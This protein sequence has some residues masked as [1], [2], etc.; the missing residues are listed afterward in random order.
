MTGAVLYICTYT[1][2]QSTLFGDHPQLASRPSLLACPSNLGWR[3]W[4][5]SRQPSC[6]CPMTCG[7]ATHGQHAR[8]HRPTQMAHMSW[9]HFILVC[10][11]G[12][13][14]GCSSVASSPGRPYLQLPGMRARQ[15][16]AWP[17]LRGD[18]T[19]PAQT[20]KQYD[21]CRSQSPAP[22][23]QLFD[24]QLPPNGSGSG[25]TLE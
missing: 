1:H 7:P 2:G 3:R 23:Q 22:L 17:M 11:W 20:P 13:P 24:K 19:R 8:A 10:R 14:A 25:P 9:S 4:S 5:P 21:T 18:S 16:R 15:Q 6:R 12:G